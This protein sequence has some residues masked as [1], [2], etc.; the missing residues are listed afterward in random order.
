MYSCMYLANVRK[1]T[2]CN[3][4]AINNILHSISIDSFSAKKLQNVT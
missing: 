2:V 3:E 1:H 4:M